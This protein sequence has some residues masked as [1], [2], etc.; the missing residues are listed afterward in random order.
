[1]AVSQSVSLGVG[2]CVFQMVNIPDESKSIGRSGPEASLMVEQDVIDVNGW[3]SVGF[4][5]FRPS[6]CLSVE[7]YQSVCVCGCQQ[8]AVFLNETECDGLPQ[9]IIY[10]SRL[11][12]L[13]V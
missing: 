1:M 2:L 4:A 8:Q 11:L 9:H 5:E 7:F 13:A 10:E 12:D 6:A 3:Q